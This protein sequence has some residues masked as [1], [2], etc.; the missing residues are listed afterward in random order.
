[1][2]F[3]CRRSKPEEHLE[4][5]VKDGTFGRT[6]DSD[7]GE[8]CFDVLTTCQAHGID[9][10]RHLFNRGWHDAEPTPAQM[11]YEMDEVGGQRVAHAGSSSLVTPLARTF[12]RSS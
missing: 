11:P 6:I 1:M 3:E 4:G 5:L 10:S 9:G 2:G 12:A 7:S 8:G